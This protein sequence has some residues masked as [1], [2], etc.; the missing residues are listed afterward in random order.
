[1]RHD[2]FKGLQ[3]PE[4]II[5]KVEKHQKQLRGEGKYMW[6]LGVASA[7]VEQTGARRLSQNS[8]SASKRFEADI[9]TANRNQHALRPPNMLREHITSH[10]NNAREVATLRYRQACENGAVNKS[11]TTSAARE[12]S[13]GGGAAQHHGIGAGLVAARG[14]AKRRIRH[15]SKASKE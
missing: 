7:S 4:V 2:S 10:S 1:V 6:Q 15:A 9:F 5:T 12:H 14:S 3:Q 13:A 8:N 11:V